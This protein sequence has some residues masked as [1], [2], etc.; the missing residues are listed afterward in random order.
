[1]SKMHEIEVNVADETAAELVLLGF[2]TRDP[3]GGYTLTDKGS[4]WVREWC[5]KQA[6][7][8]QDDGA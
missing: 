6:Q 3:D 2:W 7:A 4:K 1:M 8:M 5:R